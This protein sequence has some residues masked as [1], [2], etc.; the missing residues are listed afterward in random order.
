LKV[1][2]RRAVNALLAGSAMPHEWHGGV[3][4]LLSKREPVYELENLRPLTLLHTTY[5]IF[6]SVVNYWIQRQLELH[7]VIEPTQTGSMHG[8]ETYGSVAKLKYAV[9]ETKERGGKLYVAYI[10]FYSAFCSLSMGKLMGLLQKLG[11]H[12]DDVQLL[13]NTYTGAWSQVSTQF[14]DTAEIPLRRGTCQGCP[15]SPTTFVLFLNLCL[16]HLQA[17]GGGITFR[18]QYFEKGAEGAQEHVFMNHA[19]FVDDLG[20][21]CNSVEEMNRL[22]ESLS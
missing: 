14:G 16:R 4:K 17:T 3:I 10:D 9:E 1:V 12:D 5:K 20:L 19:G 22:L 15:L 8:R 13:K 21:L 18:A 7:G 2:I 11:L 6:T